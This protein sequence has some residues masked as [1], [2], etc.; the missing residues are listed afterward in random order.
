MEDST[1]YRAL[2]SGAISNAEGSPVFEGEGEINP[3]LGNFDSEDSSSS[4]GVH[5][6]LAQ[7]QDLD[8]RAESINFGHIGAMTLAVDSRTW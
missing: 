3:E 1:I 7:R 8:V 5:C 2:H 6:I 4:G